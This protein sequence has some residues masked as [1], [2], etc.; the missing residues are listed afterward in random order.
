MDVTIAKE[1]TNE[2]AED[3]ASAADAFGGYYWCDGD[4]E[5]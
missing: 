1:D 4:G 5:V 3:A 2:V